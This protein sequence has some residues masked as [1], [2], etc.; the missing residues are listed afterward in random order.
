MRADERKF[1]VAVARRNVKWGETPRN[2]AYKMGMNHKRS[3][4]LCKKWTDRG[5]YNYGVS[6]DLGW[7]TDAGFKEAEK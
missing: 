3:W 7:L 4:Y 5:W 6:V 1:L 2:I